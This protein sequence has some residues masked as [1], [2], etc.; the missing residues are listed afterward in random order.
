MGARDAVVGLVAL[1]S[2]ANEKDAGVRAAAVS[3]LGKLADKGAR[4]AVEAALQDPHPF[5]RDAARIALRRL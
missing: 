1:T 2:T 4:S 5:V 3:S